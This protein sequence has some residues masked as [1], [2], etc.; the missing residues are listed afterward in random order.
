MHHPSLMAIDAR[1][2]QADALR[3]HCNENPYGP[4]PGCVEAA[5]KELEAWCTAYPDTER[6][7]LRG[8][9]AEAFDMAPEM[10]AVSNGTDELVLMTALALL[11]HGDQVLITDTTFPGYRAAATLAGAGCRSVGLRGCRVPAADLAAAM[12]GDVRLAY[13][14]N[15]HNPA[16]TV[17]E[18]DEIEQLI[19]TAE[20]AGV[21]PVFDEAYI[22]FAPA[23]YRSTVDAVR[24]GRRLLV[25][26]T[27]SKAWGLAALRAGYAVGP[28]DIIERV[29]RAGGTLPFSV[30]R[31]AQQAAAAALQCDGYLD[32]IRTRTA[33]ARDLLYAGL[34]A[35]GLGYTRSEANFVLV[36]T[37]GD[38]SAL[39]ARLAEEQRVLVRDLTSFGLP[40]HLR[41]TVGT[42][43]QVDRFCQA[44][45][46][47]L[48]AVDTHKT[49]AG[50]GAPDGAG[51]V[52]PR[53]AVD[54]ATLFNGYVGSSAVFALSELGVWDLLLA[55]GQ[56]MDSLLAATHADR[57][58]LLALLRTAA[59]LGYVSLDEAP[60]GGPVTGVALTSA[61][62]D[63]A[64]LS[65]YF[66]WCVGGY[67]EVLRNL[68]D[69]ATGERAFG[70]DVSRDGAKI[71]AGSGRV[72]RTL[73]LPV[74]EAVT[75]G[76]EYDMVA[77]LGCGD[78]TRL[79]R[80]C[81]RAS[82]GR[83]LG[84]EVN[85]AARD[86][87]QAR[88]ADAGLADRI[89]IVCADVLGRSGGQTFPGVDLVASFL[90]M[91]DL[92]NAASDPADVVRS[93]RAMFPD[94]KRFLVGD[95]V[96]QDWSDPAEPLPVFSLGFELVHAYMQT[97]IL[98]RST[99]ERA[100]AAGGLRVERCEPLGA[101][102]TWLW[103]LSA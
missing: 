98:S 16:G 50:L 34:D 87:A 55:G 39:G 102:S 13:I 20:D 75:A 62:Q 89:E 79:I 26:R 37:G 40:G 60:G 19:G 93:L 51:R 15:P 58:G 42:P 46:A 44:L 57:T 61:G 28:A 91:H 63:V 8:R 41:V 68:A 9:L 69:L 103:L 48:A 90:M 24:A 7:A 72:G 94:A 53:Q 35:L 64:R 32:D 67:H 81:R 18:P 95:T 96:G 30:N 31:V 1:H 29:R 14:C 21:V 45:A 85:A 49:P 38:S 17:L 11:E 86:T 77:D 25:L 74:E 70:T 83:G 3:L 71:S 10:V 33:A 27:F 99:Y 101:P 22:E 2:Q 43:D 78:A 6:A 97:P 84:I 82:S 76:L 4:P 66:T 100:F 92:F 54:P 23:A 36:H 65:G 12:S 56:R 73:M 47:V 5:T 80:L 88:V 52:A 59:L